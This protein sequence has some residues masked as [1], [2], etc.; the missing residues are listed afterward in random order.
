M[1]N[2]F[3]AMPTPFQFPRITVPYDLRPLAADKIT[4]AVP[5]GELYLVRMCIATSAEVLLYDVNKVAS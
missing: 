2:N 3:R 5:N 4:R 1:P